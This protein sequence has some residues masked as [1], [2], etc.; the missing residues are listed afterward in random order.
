MFN[1]TLGRAAF[2]VVPLVAALAL[3]PGAGAQEHDLTGA[4]LFDVTVEGDVTHPVVVFEQD[5]QELT[6]QYS[7]ATLGDAEIEGTIEGDEFTFA[8]Q[9]SVEV[10]GPVSVTYSGT[11]ED[12]ETLSGRMDLGGMIQGTFTARPH[13]DEDP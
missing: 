10:L 13:E 4:W 1:R 8:L 11:V 6:G 2:A 7:S 9:A 12:A 3:A 5:G